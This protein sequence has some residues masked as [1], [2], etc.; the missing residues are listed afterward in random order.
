MYE[1]LCEEHISFHLQMINLILSYDY[2]EG[3]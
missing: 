2:F 1:D 3:D